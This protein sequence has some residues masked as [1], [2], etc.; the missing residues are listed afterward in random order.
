MNTFPKLSTQAVTQYPAV[1]ESSQPVRVLQ[2]TDG[3]DQRYLVQPKPLRLWRINMNQLNED[4]VQAIENFFTN[5]QGQYSVFTFPDPFSGR[6]VSSCRF[7]GPALI[8]N[9]LDVDNASA[10]YW[11]V[12]INA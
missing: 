10:S 2:F 1:L 9:Y 11:V 6:D 4:E 3:S 8:T 5:Q 7:A 12:E